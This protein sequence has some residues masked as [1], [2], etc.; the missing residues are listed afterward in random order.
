MRK[1]KTVRLI[2]EA[3]SLLA[4]KAEDLNTSMAEIA[5]EAIFMF[6]G[7]EDRDREQRDYIER[8]NKA[9]IKLQKRIPVYLFISAA[10]GTIAGIVMGVM[11]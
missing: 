8:I 9:S 5:S 7:Q 4:E 1:D 6:V 11:L 3:H 10:I 2:S